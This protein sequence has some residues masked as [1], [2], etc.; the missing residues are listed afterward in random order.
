MKNPFD[1]LAKNSKESAKKWKNVKDAHRI[2]S[3]CC[4]QCG[5]P[6]PINTDIAKCAYCGHRFMLIEKR[7][8]KTNP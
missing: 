3:I 5:A 8:D 1:R 4:E 6:R 7:I 2:T